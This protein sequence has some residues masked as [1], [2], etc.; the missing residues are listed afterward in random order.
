MSTYFCTLSLTVTSTQQ[1]Y[2]HTFIFTHSLTAATKK[3]I[4]CLQFRTYGALCSLITASWSLSEQL[5]HQ[6]HLST[7]IQTLF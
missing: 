5:L 7:Q 3:D 1:N 4:Y 2:F 6:Q